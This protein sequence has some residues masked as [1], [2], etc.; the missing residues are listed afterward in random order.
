MKAKGE[1]NFDVNLVKQIELREAQQA[2][3]QV[4]INAAAS[5]YRCQ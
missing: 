2:K 1:L 3:V 5:K 4:G